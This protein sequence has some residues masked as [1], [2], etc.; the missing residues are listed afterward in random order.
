MPIQQTHY[1]P[2]QIAESL[3]VSESSVKRWCDR[4]VI[5]TIRTVG[6]HRRITPEGLHT[7]LR[8]S[9]RSLVNPGVLGFAVLPSTRSTRIPGSDDPQRR[10]FREALASGDEE[11]CQTIF[12][13]RVSDGWSVAEVAEDLI[14]EAMKG[15]GD[16]WESQEIDVYQER[17]SCG[18]C[19]RLLGQAR[20]SLPALPESAP[21][22]IGGTASGD[23]YEL[24]T[25][26]VELA[27]R[28]AG[29]NATNLGTNLP[30][31]SFIQ[32]AY[33]YKPKL[34]W[35]SISIID[36]PTLF[37]S[38]QIRLA[39]SLDDDVSLIVGGRGLNDQ[40]RP[41]LQYTAHCDS[42]RHLV[43]LATVMRNSLTH[44]DT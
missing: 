36:N 25:V 27:L 34:L 24:A 23:P 14:S 42:L 31:E 44:P 33:D 20:A 40:I 41:N 29:W 16:A 2:K 8:T 12:A 11:T 6:G 43:E 3:S 26:M 9:N 1:S 39:N 15:V 10:Q 22:A 21:V 17:R 32:A 5:P 19:L 37:T 38:A 13:E 28:E 7:F 18:I 30:I 35:L 4:G